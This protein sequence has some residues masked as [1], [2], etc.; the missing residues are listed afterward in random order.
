MEAFMK[1]AEPLDIKGVCTLPGGE[2]TGTG[3]AAPVNLDDYPPFSKRPM[4]FT[5]QEITR[6]CPVACKYCQ[7]S[8][9]QGGRYRHRSPSFVLKYTKKLVELGVNDLRFITP[10][11]L[12][13]GTEEQGRPDLK[14]LG[15]FL[16]EVR[17]IA[18][19]RRVYYGTFPS[20]VWPSS[21][22]EEAVALLRKYTSNEG[23]VVGAQTGSDRLLREIGRSH[24]VQDV[25]S[26]AEHILKAGF[27]ANIDFMFGL[28]GETEED[29]QATIEFMRELAAMDAKVHSHTFI[30]LSGT[31]YGNFEPPVLSRK[32]VKTLESLTGRGAQYGA[33]KKQMAESRKIWMFRKILRETG[34][35]K[36][37][38]RNSDKISADSL[39]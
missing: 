1:G 5:Y 25:R 36:R 11:C 29:E 7:A 26:A 13:Y 23:I 32:T 14:H 19:D 38:V 16:Y 18:G 33:W 12:S 37:A 22:T 10:D 6:G 31:P 34:D 15:D 3:F 4:K 2:F 27:T 28:P 39:F 9:I 21:V 35:I 20:E 8:Y 24:T 30:P 17:K